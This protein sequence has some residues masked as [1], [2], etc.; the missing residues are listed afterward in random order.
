MIT[1]SLSVFS[2]L[3]AAAIWIVAWQ[4]GASIPPLTEGSGFFGLAAMII[5][6]PVTFVLYPLQYFLFRRVAQELSP[7]WIHFR[8]WFTVVAGLICMIVLFLVLDSAGSPRPL[9]TTPLGLPS[10]QVALQVSLIML[11]PLVTWIIYA[12]LMDFFQSKR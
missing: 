12:S 3:F 11:S 2:S 8:R 1:A 10:R 5:A 7:K 6:P 4:I 9:L